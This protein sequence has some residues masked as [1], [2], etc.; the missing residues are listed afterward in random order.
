MW[1]AKQHECRPHCRVRILFLSRYHSLPQSS[2]W[3]SIFHFH[4]EMFHQGSFRKAES[5]FQRSPAILRKNHGTRHWT[6]VV[7]LNELA[8]LYRTQ[9]HIAD[10][11]AVEQ[12]L[13]DFD[14]EE[15]PASPM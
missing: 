6:V 7:T 3:C 9:G 13:S 8:Q 15:S 2:S 11:E 5:L 10:A 1:V 4:M 12:R 14:G